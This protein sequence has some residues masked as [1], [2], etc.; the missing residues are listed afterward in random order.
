MHDACDVPGRSATPAEVRRALA[1]AKTIAVVGYSENPDRPSHR[2]AAYLQSQGYR[3]IAVNPG[4]DAALGGKAYPR[5]RDIPGGA[6][7]VDIFRKPEAVP[8]VVEDAL[9]AGAE[10]VWMQPGAANDAAADRARAQGL[11]V[12]MDRC[13]KTEHHA[14]FGGPPS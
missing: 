7:I 3:V 9:A 8:E 5:V 4:L 11:L 2:V 12:V 13:I 1:G 10:V 6:D 14:A